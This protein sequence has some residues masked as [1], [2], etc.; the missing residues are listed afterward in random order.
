MNRL[1][2]TLSVI[3][4]SITLIAQLNAQTKIG[5]PFFDKADSFFQKNVKDGLLDYSQLGNNGELAE[6]TKNIADANIKG[7]SDLEMQAFYINAYNLLVIN[8]IAQRYP[9]QS[10]ND[11]PGFFDAKKHVIAGKKM[12]LNQLEKGNLFKKFDE[13]RFHFVLVCGAKGCPPITNF[14]YRPEKLDEQMQA[15]TM[16]ALNDSRFVNV[17]DPAK[18]KV[19]VSKIFD[20]YSKDFGGKNNLINYV[21]RFRTEK[22]RNNAKTS[23]LDYDWSLN[24]GEMMA[25]KT[26]GKSSAAITPVSTSNNASRYVV[27]AAIPK[28]TTETK[29]FNNLYTQRVPSG[30]PNTELTDR[31]NFFTSSLSFLYGFTNRFNAGFDVRYR[32]VSNTG[33]P[34]SPF[35]VL[36]NKEADSRRSTIANLGP[37]IRWAPTSAL[38][39][40]SIQSSFVFPVADDLEGNSELNRPF[41][42][43]DSPIWITQFFNDFSI[44]D[45]FSIFTELDFWWEDIG[46]DQLNRLATPA[47][48]IFSYF[49]NPKTTVYVLTNYAPFW[50]ENF[51][52]FAQAG[53]GLKYQ[54]TPQF[55][56]ELLYSDFTNKGLRANGG[57]AATFNLGVRYSK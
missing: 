23:F 29:I 7:L 24:Q 51:D 52:Y 53:L 19:G 43:W 16:K 44:G 55:E 33:L 32:R 18:N 36:T 5:T 2:T 35:N 45:N 22:I 25:D 20:W 12:T 10:A 38:P 39:N 4:F 42:D 27:S 54:F 57:Q 49:P 11:V 3:I 40:F 30:G 34:S 8:S 50:Q 15:Q 17:I 56:I 6:L 31:N 13:P 14:A 37:K 46:N 47:T 21:N 28:G 26:S 48:A 1:K 9:I 41:V